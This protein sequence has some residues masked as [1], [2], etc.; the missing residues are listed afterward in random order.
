[1][2]LNMLHTHGKCTHYT[3]KHFKEKEKNKCSGCEGMTKALGLS[4]SIP[5]ETACTCRRHRTTIRTKQNKD[6]NR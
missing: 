4:R 5:M 3:T 1:M 2:A 6:N